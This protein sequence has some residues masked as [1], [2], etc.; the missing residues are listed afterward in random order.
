MTWIFMDS[1]V[2]VRAT[3]IFGRWCVRWTWCA[4]HRRFRPL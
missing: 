1:P 2:R 4:R 3:V